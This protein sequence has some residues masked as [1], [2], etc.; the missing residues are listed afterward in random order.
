[1]TFDEILEQVIALLKRQGRVSYRALKMRFD[2][3]DDEYLDVLKE[4]LIDAQRLATDED[5]RIMVWAGAM[6][7]PEAMSQSDQTIKPSVQ[8]ELPTQVVPTPPEPALPEAERR[9]LTVMFC[10]LADSTKLSGQLDP[11]D[12]RDVI[13]AYQ[14][15]SAEVIERYD[16]YIAQHLG[17]GLMVYFG[18]PQAHEDDALRAVHA[19]LGILA[20]MRPLNRR[21]ERDKGIRLAVRIGLHTGPVVVGEIGGGNRHEHLALG[22]NINI[23]SRLEGLASPNTVLASDITTRLVQSAFE[24]ENLGRHELK[25]IAELMSVFRIIGERTAVEHV[26]TG[27]TDSDLAL[28]GRGPE[29]ALLLDRWAQSKDGRGPAT[30]GAGASPGRGAP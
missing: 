4:E 21:L 19:G 14:A 1:M 25:G 15:T 23:A 9:Q 27:A 5:G 26:A 22:E 2:E 28:V 29:L 16:G 24:G 3:I 7:M 11:E 8:Q 13:R 18:W 10:D 17:D 30:P 12:F 20:A 6:E